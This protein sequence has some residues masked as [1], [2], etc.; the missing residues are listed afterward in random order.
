[1]QQSQLSYRAWLTLLAALLLLVAWPALVLAASFDHGGLAR[2]VLER[3]IRPGYDALV[4]ETQSLKAQS[5]A[6]CA[7]AQ[8]G[9]LDA[10]R[11]AFR[12]TVLA[13]SRMEHIQF[14]PV[15]EERR[16]TRML[17]WPDRKSLGR[18]QIRRALLKKDAS[19][20]TKEALA[21]KSVAVQGLGA[22][23]QLLFWE[24]DEDFAK[25]ADT[26]D[27]RCGYLTAASA[28][29][30]AIAEEIVSGW[31]S[32]GDAERTL[33]T[34]G[35]DN[36]AYLSDTEVTLEIA[37]SLLVGLEKLRDVKIAGPLGLRRKSARRTSAA[38]ERSGLS[39]AA[40]IADL[41][42]LIELFRKGGIME[43]LDAHETGIGKAI[44]FD[45]E[46]ALKTLKTLPASMKQAA[47]DEDGT[48]QDDLIAV[49]FPLKNARGEANRV[50]AE[51]AG[52]TLGFNALD[53]D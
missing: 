28:N 42:G 13:W 29:V 16:G 32:G 53:G 50:L 23:E 45:M 17:Y 34:P 4:K 37:K 22:I 7:A 5:E 33:L 35:P 20:L 14:G 47:T 12:S 31:S 1:M 27:H 30:A 9:S 40:I 41:E 24:A 49:G 21:A 48:A 11:A 18:K 2:Q 46:Q 36:P 38:F 39:T 10:V 15:M 43:R 51:A 26:R 19:V 3:H 6:F 8:D 25:A 44:L 52:L